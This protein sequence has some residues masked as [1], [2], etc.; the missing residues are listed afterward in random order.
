MTVPELDVRESTDA[1]IVEADLPGVDV[2]TTTEVF[3]GRSRPSLRTSDFQSEKTGSTPVGTAM[4]S[5]G[6]S[7]PACPFQKSSDYSIPKKPS[8]CSLSSGV[9][10]RSLQFA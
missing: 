7:Y 6:F 1:F 10:A 5:L 3:R 4:I 2:Y 9:S 8:V